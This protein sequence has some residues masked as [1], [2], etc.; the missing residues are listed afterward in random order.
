MPEKNSHNKGEEEM[1][2]KEAEKQAD[3]IME[4]ITDGENLPIIRE[5]LEQHFQ[6]EKVNKK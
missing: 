4:N 3:E 5:T 2:K 1:N 6:R